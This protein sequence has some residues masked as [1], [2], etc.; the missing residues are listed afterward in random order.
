MN[1]HDGSSPGSLTCVIMI[2]IGSY[3]SALSA[4]AL[5]EL[6]VDS[7]PAFFVVASIM[8]PKT[9]AAKSKLSRAKSQVFEASSASAAGCDEFEEFQ[10]NS[11]PSR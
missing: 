3:F 11:P 6:Q 1:Y 10:D 8:A 4:P 9:P 5:S 7:P 2:V